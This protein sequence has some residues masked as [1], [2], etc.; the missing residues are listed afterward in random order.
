LPGVVAEV[1]TAVAVDAAAVLTSVAEVVMSA[2]D[3]LAAHGPEVSTVA[4][5]GSRAV[6]VTSA[7]EPSVADG[8][9]HFRARP[10]VAIFVAVLPFRPAI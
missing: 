10:A 3:I 4:V 2:A 7:A 9:Q 1:V 6:D 8:Q 5:R